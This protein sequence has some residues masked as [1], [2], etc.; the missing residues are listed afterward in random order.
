MSVLIVAEVGLMHDGKIEE[1]HRLIDTAQQCG[2]DA[3]KFQTHIAEAETLKNAPAPAY[4]QSESRFDYFKRTA[5]TKA[6][7]QDV[8]DACAKKKILFLSSAFSNEAVDL[9]NAVGVSMF[10]VPSGEVTNLPYLERIA[11]T[12]KPVLLSS[13]MS[14]WAELDEA[15]ATIRKYNSKLTLFQCTSKYPCPYEHVGLNVIAEMRDRYK[16]PVGL[17]DHTLTNFASYAAVALGA[18]VIEKHLVISRSAYGSDAKHSLEPVEFKAMVEGIRAIETMVDHPV[19]KNDLASFKDM[20]TIFEKS[21]VSVRD[22]PAGAVI[23]SDMIGVKKPGGGVPPKKWADVIGSR[24]KR[25]IPGDSVIQMNDI[26]WSS[27]GH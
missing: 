15:V 21:V 5:F 20:K 11:K 13:G 24:S 4:F 23:T 7:W 26:D 8:K 14:N 16:A 22:I 3:V 17:S 27:H 9:L 12:G 2:A 1:A 19:D 6:Q 10:K 18:T 25:A